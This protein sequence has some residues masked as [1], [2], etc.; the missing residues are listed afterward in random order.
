MEPPTIEK[1]MRC[2]GTS[3]FKLKIPEGETRVQVLW[4][5]VSNV[6]NLF[7]YELLC[8]FV[9]KTVMAALCR[10]LAVVPLC[11]NMPIALQ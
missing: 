7:S 2:R 10:I 4:L 11:K 3:L 6:V 1:G 5:S 8:L 9:D